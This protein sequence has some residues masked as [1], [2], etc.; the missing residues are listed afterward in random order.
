M[1][2]TRPSPAPVARKGC[3]TSDALLVHQLFRRH[4]VD[5]PVLVRG[6]EA[7]DTA[8]ARVVGAHVRELLDGLQRHHQAQDLLL[9]GILERRSAVCALH[10]GLMKAQHESIARMIVPLRVVLPVWEA[11]ADPDDGE[12]VAQGLDEV[13]AALLVHLALEEK[14]VLPTAADV[15]TQE[16]WDQVGEQ[17]VAGMPRG[18][19]LIQLGWMLDS[20]PEDSRDEWLRRNLPAPARALWRAVGRPRFAAHRARVYGDAL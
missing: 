6:V 2:T 11:D 5:A 19:L 17:G 1:T 9:W 3:D 12:A 13:R 16:E 7:G 20:V 8:R 4:F 14:R 10:T 15:M 18:R